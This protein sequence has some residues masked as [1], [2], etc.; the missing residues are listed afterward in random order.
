MSLSRSSRILLSESLRKVVVVALCVSLWGLVLYRADWYRIKEKSLRTVVVARGWIEQKLTPQQVQATGCTLPAG[1][2]HCATITQ[3]HT[4]NGS[5]NSSNFPVGVIGTCNGGSGTLACSSSNADWR[6]V[7]NSGQIQNTI[8]AGGILQGTYTS[9]GTLSGTGLCNLNSFNNS[10]TGGTATVQV[11]SGSIAGGTVLNITAAGSGSTAYPTQAT[12]TGTCTGG[13]TA[14]G[15]ATVSTR[16]TF[17]AI[18]A[19]FMITSDSAGSTLLKFSWGSYTA[20]SGQVEVYHKETISNS[21]D[22][23][24]YAFWGNSSQ[25]TFLGDVPNTWDSDFKAVYHGDNVIITAGKVMALFDET[26]NHVSNDLSNGSSGITQGTGAAAGHGM[27]CDASSNLNAGSYSAPTGS[28]TR[29]LEIWWNA[30]STAPPAGR[31]SAIAG[32]GSSG[33]GTGAW[34]ATGGCPS[35]VCSVS[36]YIQSSVQTFAAFGYL[37]AGG[38]TV[39]SNPHYTALTYPTGQTTVSQTSMYYD[40]VL[41][42]LTFTSGGSTLN[43]SGGAI[44]ICGGSGGSQWVSGGLADEFRISDIARSAD[45]ITATYNNFHA[46]GSFASVSNATSAGGKVAHKVISSQ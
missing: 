15:T 40:G 13:A 9:G 31:V 26:S 1:W 42:T 2:S 21:S 8:A 45:W 35:G 44:S 25:T 7:A 11:T 18:P 37:G 29:T 39:D 10:N 30:E 43:T 5:S 38:P 19:D 34:F 6:T 36:P 27:V 16:V 4:Q 41:Q 3:F 32:W 46:P 14:S 22:T 20:S 24:S 17:F 33:G 12:F 23:L 28:A